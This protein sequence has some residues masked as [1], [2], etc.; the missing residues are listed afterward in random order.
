VTNALIVVDVQNDF[1]EGGSLPV[2]GG[3]SVAV[4]IANMLGNIR[5]YNMYNYIVATKDWHLPNDSNGGHITDNPDYENS[6]PSHCIQGTDG[7]MFH[8]AIAEVADTFDRIFYKGQGFP[9]YSGFQ[10]QA[11]KFNNT[12]PSVF[13]GP[14]LEEHG[15]VNVDVCG[16]AADFCVKETAIDA[17]Q[18]G[19]NTNILPRLTAAVGGPGQVEAAVAAVKKIQDKYK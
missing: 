16:L 17:I 2:H 9:H 11:L 13:L 1:C 10:G 15:V 3:S 8:P 18:W 7:A 12:E 4:A 14:W 5:G 19:F 6:W